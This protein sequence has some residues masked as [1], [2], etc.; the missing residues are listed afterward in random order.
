MKSKHLLI[1]IILQIFL[2]SCISSRKVHNDLIREDLLVYYPIISEKDYWKELV[3][4]KYCEKNEN[5][6]FNLDSFFYYTQNEVYLNFDSLLIERINDSNLQLYEA[7]H[8]YNYYPNSIEEII[9]DCYNDIDED[10]LK[11]LSYEYFQNQ[12]K[13]INYIR[14][15]PYSIFESK[16][17][18]KSTENK[19]INKLTL[20]ESNVGFEFVEKW[21]FDAKKFEFTKEVISYQSINKIREEKWNDT[22]YKSNYS[23]IFKDI[24]KKD[25]Y[26]PFKKVKYEFFFENYENYV[27]FKDFYYTPDTYSE[28]K[29][30]PFFTSYSKYIL[31][32]TLIEKVFK[33]DYPVYDFYKVDTISKSKAFSNLGAN[34]EQDWVE[35]YECDFVK[36]F[37]YRNFDITEI[38]SVIFIEEWYINPENLHI[39]KEVIGI[40][41]VRTYY[42]GQDADMEHP[43]KTIPFT[44]YFD[45]SKK[46]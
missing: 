33:E 3:E 39:K 14:E 21:N 10:T 2:S 20:L 37:F 26:I 8:Q 11:P 4:C 16:L 25:K 30:S 45:E 15:F 24:H 31:V 22:I 6:N 34:F 1:L 38:R 42:E 46:F 35:S 43:I 7:F 13:F 19:N 29:F 5:F 27:I 18:N 28:N 9:I 17:L 41:P 36:A 40:A 32:N 44:V 23:L 12:N